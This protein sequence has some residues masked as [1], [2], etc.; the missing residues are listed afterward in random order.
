MIKASDASSLLVTYHNTD[1]SGKAAS[2]VRPPHLPLNTPPRPSLPVALRPASHVYPRCTPHAR[3]A[4]TFYGATTLCFF[5]TLFFSPL[6]RA[7]HKQYLCFMSCSRTAR[8][9]PPPAGAF[10]DLLLIWEATQLY[11]ATVCGV[12]VIISNNDY[13]RVLDLFLAY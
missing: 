2:S 12:H 8:G 4:F 11:L 5:L 13:V 1:S 9:P 7:P 3:N 10:F 6:T